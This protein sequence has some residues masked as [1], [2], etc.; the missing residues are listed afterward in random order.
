MSRLAG[1]WPLTPPTECWQ[2]DTSMSTSTHIFE[3]R[4]HGLLSYD[5]MRIHRSQDCE[6]ECG[7][8]SSLRSSH[9]AGMPIAGPQWTLSRTVD[10]THLSSAWVC[11]RHACHQAGRPLS[12]SCSA[13][14]DERWT[15][16]VRHRL[17]SAAVW[18][19][20]FPTYRCPC[21][22]HWLRPAGFDTRVGWAR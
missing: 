11:I 9:V 19:L 20:I 14:L 18:T 15:I 7:R 4:R 17:L 22:S 12:T 3:W 16:R 10:T 8:S 1:E 13:L 2:C 6:R 5:T 21:F